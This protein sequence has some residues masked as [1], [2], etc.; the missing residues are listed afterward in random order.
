MSIYK[1]AQLI[2]EKSKGHEFG[3]LQT[4]RK[5]IKSL[6]RKPINRIFSNKS[7][8]DRG[9]AFHSGGRSEM[10]FN[11]G[12]EGDKFRYG[13][14]FSLESSRALPDVSILYPKVLRLNSIVREKPEL[15]SE[16][17]LWYWTNT[18]RSGTAKM[19][20]IPSCWL[21][22]NNFIFFGKQKNLQEIDIEEILDTFD[23]M[24]PIYLEVESDE[25]TS[26]TP[27]SDNDNPD[28]VFKPGTPK[29]VFNRNV[30]IIEKKTNV[31]VRHSL[32]QEKLLN[33]LVGEYGTDRVR[34]EHPHH[35]NKIDIVLKTDDTYTFYEIK[36]GNNAKSC[37]RQAMGQLLEYGFWPG[38]R[39]AAE[40]VVVGE[41]PSNA[42][43]NDYLEFLR[44]T[45]NIPIR[46]LSVRVE[47]NVTG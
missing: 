2:N 24:L 8:S 33:S 10:Q 30:T 15:F 7:I 46:Y 18:Q 25:G 17:S 21:H 4:F 44:K 38:V 27:I 45:F 22:P 26:E 6:Q 5:K 42:Q 20:E 16:Y 14:A 28:F 41:P 23:Q 36:T 35:G 1:L 11:I 47:N 13:L 31:D 32:I 39:N 37:I 34:L 9:W 43:T 40:L 12:L 3:R 29:L 19:S